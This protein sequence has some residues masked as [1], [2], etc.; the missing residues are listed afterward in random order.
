MGVM[1]YAPTLLLS[2]DIKDKG[3]SLNPDLVVINVDM[4]DFQK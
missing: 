4:S 2:G 1:S 3:L